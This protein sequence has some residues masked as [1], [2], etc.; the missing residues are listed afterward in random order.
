MQAK[1]VLRAGHRYASQRGASPGHGRQGQGEQAHLGLQSPETP[2]FPEDDKPMLTFSRSALAAASLALG[3]FTSQQAGAQTWP[4][5]Q[6]QAV[7]SFTAG[8]STDIVGRIILQKLAELWGVPVVPENRAG[9]G[10]SIGMSYVARAN[11]DG[12]TLLI[13]STGHVVVPFM[14][15]NMPVDVLRDFVDVAGLAIAPNVL[16]VPARSP[17]KTL[18]ELV[19]AAKAAPNTI[20]FASAGVGSAT[21]LALERFIAATGIQVTHIP[22]KG[23]PEVISGLLNNSVDCYWSPISPGLSNIKAGNLR[24]LAVSTARRSSLLPT[25]PTSAEAGVANAESPIWF[26][27]W[28]PAAT[29]KP[30]VSKLA[31][32]VRKVLTMPDTR[33]KLAALGNDPLMMGPDEFARFVR[34]EYQVYRKLVADAGIKPQ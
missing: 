4:D 15:A 24:A 16:V 17:W 1:P 34:D 18:G 25:V 21:H 8:S 27:M 7:I 6:V 10:G 23:T 32:D 13:D 11:P 5:R 26:G 30:I 33:E 3:L 2:P 31:A 20:N 29:P 14:Y 28:A 9:A 22:Y 12:Y 19:A